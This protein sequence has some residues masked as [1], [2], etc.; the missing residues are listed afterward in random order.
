V[1]QITAGI[2][3]R[4]DVRYLLANRGDTPAIADVSGLSRFMSYCTERGIAPAAATD[5]T[6]VQFGGELENKRPRS[7]RAGHI[8]HEQS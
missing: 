4:P 6:F 1:L 2:V 7:R 3:V 8:Q 5:G